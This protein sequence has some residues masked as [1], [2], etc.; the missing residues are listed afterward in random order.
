LAAY[1]EKGTTDLFWEAK[2]MEVEW[3]RDPKRVTNGYR[4]QKLA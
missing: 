1:S 2:F 3:V 4:E